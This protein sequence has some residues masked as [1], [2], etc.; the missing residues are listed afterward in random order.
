MGTVIRNHKIKFAVAVAVILMIAAAAVLYATRPYAIHVDGTKVED[1]YAV[2][3]DGKELFLVDNE[4]T[5]KKVIETVLDEYSPEG[6]QINSIVVD[7]KLSTVDRDLKRSEE[8]PLV[9]TEEE[10]VAYVL[11]ANK[12]EDPLFSVTINAEIGEVD[13]IKV[14]KLYED[15]E[16]LFEEESELKSEGREGSQIVTNQ[17]TSVNGAVLTSDVVD[18][19]V[20]NE[21]TPTVIYRGTR[22]R[23]AG[24]NGKVIGIGNGA[25]VA[26]FAVQYIGNP[27][28]WG[29][30]S[31]TKG[32]DCSGFVYAVY[33]KMGVDMPRTGQE[34]AGKG[35]PISQAK[36][37]D[38]LIYSGHVA[39]YI[40]GGKIVHAV[41]SS[42]G[43]RVT[44]M[45]YTGTPYACRR[46][47]E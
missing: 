37:G 44:D 13:S 42:L 14:D 2:T 5:A 7:K 31:L 12:Q 24:F 29:G 30:T 10:A 6:A 46:I 34:N 8:P 4:K 33:R 43:I 21:A 28:K 11:E 1:P 22:E 16:K 17:I 19:A 9:F 3:A 47:V 25:D 36:A 38:V 27:Y 15:T 26:R 32:A 45:Y 35:V 18:T 40:G 39:I 41:N 23:P 20:V